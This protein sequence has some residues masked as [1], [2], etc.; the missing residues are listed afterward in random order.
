MAKQRFMV[1]NGDYQEL[2]TYFVER[3]PESI[4]L[5][6]GNSVSKLEIGRYF[7]ELG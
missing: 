6:C 2:E 5:V 3:R 7:K 1:G 4:F